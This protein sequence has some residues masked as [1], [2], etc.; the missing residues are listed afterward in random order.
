[1]PDKQ[2][3]HRSKNVTA[4]ARSPL[5]GDRAE[6]GFTL[7][8]VILAVAIFSVGILS[9][10]ALYATSG[11][12]QSRQHDRMLALQYAKDRLEEARGVLL[13]QGADSLTA[14]NFPDDTPQGSSKFLRQITFTAVDTRLI[15]ATATVT[16]PDGKVELKTRLLQLQ[17]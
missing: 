10:L 7:F 12:N 6:R 2:V 13:T 4:K 9:V 16:Y 8:E 14:S 11:R 1:M 17:E 5:V 3:T 15:E